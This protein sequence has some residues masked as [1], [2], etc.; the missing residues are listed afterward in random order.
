MLTIAAIF[1]YAV[2]QAG[3]IA[4]AA[5]LM[6]FHD[7]KNRNQRGRW[8]N[9]KRREKK[10]RKEKGKRKDKIEKETRTK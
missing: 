10:E 7:W 5:V 4:A 1:N 3:S 9:K 6:I 8:R 2:E